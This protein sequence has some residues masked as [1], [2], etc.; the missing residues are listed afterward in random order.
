MKYV[1]VSLLCLAAIAAYALSLDAAQSQRFLHETGPVERGSALIYVATIFLLPL[2]Y[3]LRGAFTRWY[4]IVLLAF[5]AFRELDGDKK[6]FSVGM[7]KSRQYFGDAPI[8]EKLTGILVLAFIIWALVVLVRRHGLRWRNALRRFEPWALAIGLGAFFMVTSKTVDGPRRKLAPYGIDISEEV[9]RFV[10]TYE[11]VA[12][13][14]IAVMFA[15]VV[16]LAALNGRDR[17]E[18]AQRT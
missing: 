12:E 13:L 6:L 17:T 9:K 1:L 10:I 2:A 14:G 15:V 3:G 4:A 11:E 7:L 5:F 16:L 18:I 8:L